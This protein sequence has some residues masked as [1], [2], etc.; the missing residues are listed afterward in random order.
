MP[1]EYPKEWWQPFQMD[2]PLCQE[3]VKKDREKMSQKTREGLENLTAWLKKKWYFAIIVLAVLLF[4]ESIT[5]SLII[6]LLLAFAVMVNMQKILIER[7]TGIEVV[8]F[9]ATIISIALNPVFGIVFAT[10]AIIISTIIHGKA[11][12]FLF[13][14][15]PAYALMCFVAGTFASTDIM[16]AGII[17]LFIGNA[18]FLGSTFFL[19]P[20][21]IWSNIP[22][23]VINITINAWLFMRFGEAL[24]G[25]LMV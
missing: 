23:A 20:E 17:V 8:T 4:G 7:S 12:T 15:I 14:K 9:S 19:N 10:A 25:V 13:I 22:A 24:V 21:R 16:N 3:K 18:I 11:G 5:S 6:I 1:P 2:V